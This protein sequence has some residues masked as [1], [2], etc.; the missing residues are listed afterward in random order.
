MNTGRKTLH[1]L[2]VVS[3]GVFWRK[4]AKERSGGSS[5]VFDAAAITTAETVNVDRYQFAGVHPLELGL[6]KVCGDP[7]VIDGNDREQRL[8]G[9]D[10][11]T[12]FQRSC[13][14]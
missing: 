1:D 7:D 11:I 4:E 5:H 6:F 2:D 14:R 3:A 12:D 13:V 9:L 10:A 8:A